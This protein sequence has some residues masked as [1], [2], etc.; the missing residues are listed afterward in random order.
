MYWMVGWLPGGSAGT[1]FCSGT[2]MSISFRAIALLLNFSLIGSDRRDAGLGDDVAP[3][4]HFVVD[5]LSHALGSVGEDLKTVVAQLLRN[6]RGFQNADRLGRQQLDD[7]GR[8]ICGRQETLE[9]VGDKIL[10]A[11]LDHGRHVRQIEPA[12]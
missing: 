12:M 5:A 10:V 1:S 9:G 7:R 11:E 3:L 8:R 6:L 4:R 2:E